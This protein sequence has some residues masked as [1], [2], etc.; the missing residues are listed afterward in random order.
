MECA[1]NPCQNGGTC[2]YQGEGQYSCQCSQG[3]HGRNCEL[4][5]SCFHL[6]PLFQTELVK[7]FY[8]SSKRYKGP[9]IFNGVGGLVGFGR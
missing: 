9:F 7:K 8:Y 1:G 2:D 5:K 3:Y 6:V 4:G